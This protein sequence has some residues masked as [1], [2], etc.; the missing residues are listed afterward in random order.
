[1]KKILL[2]FVAALLLA[3]CGVERGTLEVTVFNPS[4]LDRNGQL[5]EVG[6]DIVS[7]RLKLDDTTQFVIVD[8]IG[9]QVPYQLTYDGKLLFPIDVKA[10]D[11]AVYVVQVGTPQEELFDMA[12]YGRKYPERVDDVAWENDRVA[13]RTYGP[14]LQANGERAFGYDVWLKRVPELVVEDRYEKELNPATKAQI[15]SLRRMGKDSEANELYQSVSYHVDHGN[16]LDCYK[17]GP[18]LGGGAAALL[19]DD[20]IVYPYCYVGEPE[21]LD[22]GPLRFTVKLTYAPTVIKGDSAVV[23]TRIIS[24]DKGSYMNK[25]EVSYSGLTVPTPIAAGIV[26]HPE[27]PD[28]YTLEPE[29]GYVTYT[30]LSDNIH[31]GNGEIYLGIVS[32]LMSEAKVVLF[33]EEESK[34]LRGGACGHVL[35]IAEY[36]EP[37]FKHTYYWGNG[38][39]KYGFADADAW[40]AYVAEFAYK[41]QHPLGVQVK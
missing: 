10:N 23:E 28:A 35:A 38:W 17:V 32:H 2:F 11:S 18:T 33:S 27:N 20:E 15:D 1:M 37:D 25:T 26:I 19:V 39:S 30:D 41:V 3:S 16:G 34:T 6:M 24:L 22:N 36:L 31:N 9:K 13:F 8:G 12:V 21:I 5:V 7:H 29:K 40:N 4:D 14:A